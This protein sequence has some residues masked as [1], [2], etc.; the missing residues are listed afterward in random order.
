MKAEA[1]RKF[2][3]VSCIG[4]A[5]EGKDEVHMVMPKGIAVRCIQEWPSRIS[6]GS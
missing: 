5:N 4:G 3:V 2:C 6:L 1:V